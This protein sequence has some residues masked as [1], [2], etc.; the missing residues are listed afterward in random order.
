ML[1]ASYT[2]QAGAIN[3]ADAPEGHAYSCISCGSPVVLKRGRVR[4]A[5]F[6]HAANVACAATSGETEE[7]REAKLA[8]Y[9]G[10]LADPRASNVQ[11]EYPLNHCRPDVYFERDGVRVAIEVQRSD[12]TL[13]SIEL[14]TKRYSEQRIAVLWVF[15]KR[16]AKLHTWQKYI[17]TAGFG[18]CYFWLTGQIVVP[19]HCKDGE[20]YEALPAPICGGFKLNAR[21]TPWCGK[22]PGG[23][24]VMIPPSL[25]W[26]DIQPGAFWPTRERTV[27]PIETTRAVWRWQMYNVEP[28]K[29]E[30]FEAWMARMVGS[31]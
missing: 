9:R 18:R 21:A 8:I 14:R 27:A 17:Q 25:W 3:A 28:D 30:T 22:L 15:V 11:L 2:T 4:I 20:V 16:R 12:C 7:H 13:E 19:T 10:L 29:R 5:H 26:G 23:T 6:A 31:V 24:Q 1:T